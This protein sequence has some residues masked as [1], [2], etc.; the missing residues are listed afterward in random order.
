MNLTTLVS[1]MYLETNVDLL[2]GPNLSWPDAD[3]TLAA[4]RLSEKLGRSL[5][6]GDLRSGHSNSVISLSTFWP[7]C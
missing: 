6:S 2:T 4:L 3:K 7:A 5:F 1:N